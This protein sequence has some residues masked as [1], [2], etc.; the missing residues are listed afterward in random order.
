MEYLVTLYS[1]QPLEI[2]VVMRRFVSAK[3]SLGGRLATALGSNHLLSLSYNAKEASFTAT[4][5]N[6]CAVAALIVAIEHK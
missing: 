4:T 6:S 5:D 2:Q 1:K 3:G